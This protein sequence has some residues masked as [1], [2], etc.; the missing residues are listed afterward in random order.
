V[1]S[2]SSSLHEVV[3]VGISWSLS[4]EFRR[5]RLWQ[6]VRLKVLSWLYDSSPSRIDGEVDGAEPQRPRRLV[7]KFRIPVKIS[8][9]DGNPIPLSDADNEFCGTHLE[10]LSPDWALTSSLH[11]DVVTLPPSAEL[12][13]NETEGVEFYYVLKG[14]G[15]YILN[16]QVYGIS[17]GMGFIVDPGW[18][19]DVS[20]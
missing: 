3:G 4:Y 1:P 11:V 13:P 18:Y 12:V 2:S 10:L 15:S 6:H 19:V 20:P 17:V 5:R 9:L 8:D 14:D 7:E 16:E